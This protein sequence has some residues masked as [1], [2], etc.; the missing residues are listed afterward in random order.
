METRRPMA[1]PRVPTAGAGNPGVRRSARHAWRRSLA[2]PCSIRFPP[3]QGRRWSE[4]A[5]RAQK[6]AY[7]P[8]MQKLL[9]LVLVALPPAAPAQDLTPE[10]L[11]ATAHDF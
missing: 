6:V 7:T 8:G 1:T 2:H 10:R 3:G 5:R 11:R 4:D 9:G